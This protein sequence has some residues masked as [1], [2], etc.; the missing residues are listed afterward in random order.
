MWF[1]VTRWLRYR[2]LPWVTAVEARDCGRA[3]FE[4]EWS[5]YL[6]AYAPTGELR[7]RPP[8][9]RP[10]SLLLDIAR[11]HG[12]G[13]AVTAIAALLA[14]SLGWL[15]SFFLQALIDHILPGRMTSLLV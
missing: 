15:I 3:D 11:R 4:A 14:T 2:H 8:D 12:A 9:F 5:G 13:L 10:A 1:T 7:R 6:V